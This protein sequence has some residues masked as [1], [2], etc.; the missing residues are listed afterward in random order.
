MKGKLISF[1]SG[2]GGGKTTQVNL[3]EEY[4]KS[5]GFQVMVTREPGGIPLAEQLRTEVMHPD[6]EHTPEGELLLY[7]MARYLHTL[8]KIKPALEKG[9]IVITDRYYDSTTAYQGYG[10]NIDLDFV[11]RIHRAAVGDIIPNLTVYI[12]VNPEVGLSKITT[13]EFGRPDRQEAKGMD[14]HERLRQ[15]YLEIAREEPERIKVIQ[16][17]EGDIESMQKEI[18]TYV[19]KIINN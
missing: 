12:D 13:G 1:E 9:L 7:S 8:Y 5:R 17:K 16:Y 2:D 3:L 19:D 18:R 10:G 15:G 6:N 11:K 14:F 4:L